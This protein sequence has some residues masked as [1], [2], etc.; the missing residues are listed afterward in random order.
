[1][2]ILD[3]IIILIKFIFMKNIGIGGK[4]DKFNIIIVI[5]KFI[6]FVFSISSLISMNKDSE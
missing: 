1:M 4:P 3:I 2:F 6:S 5:D